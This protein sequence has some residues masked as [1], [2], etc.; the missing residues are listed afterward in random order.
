[1]DRPHELAP[2]RWNVRRDR[3]LHPAPAGHRPDSSDHTVA[4]AEE[5]FVQMHRLVGVIDFQL[6]T[7]ANTWPLS[8]S[9]EGHDA[10][11]G[12][13]LDALYAVDI[14][15]DW[16]LL[17]RIDCPASGINHDAVVGWAAGY[18]G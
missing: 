5:R 2:E 7:V 16:H 8:R 18:R 6:D 1:M 10:V 15:C 4:N 9:A 14:T 11:L 3:L 13:E 12:R 17:A